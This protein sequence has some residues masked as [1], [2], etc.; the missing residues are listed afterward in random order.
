MA[1]PA[2]SARGPVF[3]NLIQLQRNFL[4]IA[5]GTVILSLM[6][7]GAGAGDEVRTA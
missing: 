4:R 3:G 2:G 7:G 1:G 5:D 6:G